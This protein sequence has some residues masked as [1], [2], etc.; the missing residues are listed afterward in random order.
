MDLFVCVLG[1]FADL[2]SA[3]QRPDTEPVVTHGSCLSPHSSSSSS[4]RPSAR[5]S[6][7]RTSALRGPL[8]IRPSVHHAAPP[9]APSLLA[10]V[11]AVFTALP[12]ILPSHLSLHLPVFPARGVKSRREWSGVG[13]T[14]TFLMSSVGKCCVKA[15]G[16]PSHR[17]LLRR[18][19]GDWMT[20]RLCV[21]RMMLRGCSLQLMWQCV[22]RR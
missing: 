14:T 5:V 1:S 15:F 11:N 8:L 22:C 12:R 19:S 16:P 7:H 21:V 6:A 3:A 18:V 9:A 20:Q 4:R 2:R 17:G 10:G 13:P